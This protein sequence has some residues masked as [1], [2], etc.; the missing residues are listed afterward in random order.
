MAVELE[1]VEGIQEGKQDRTEIPCLRNRGVY[2]QLDKCG[3]DQDCCTATYQN[4]PEQN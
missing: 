1:E 2:Q 3:R 4:V